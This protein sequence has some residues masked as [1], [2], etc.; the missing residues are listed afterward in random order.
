MK[1]VLA[2]II[3]I[4]ILQLEGLLALPVHPVDS[5]GVKWVSG[6]KFIEYK[7]EEHE[8]WYGIARQ[9]GISYNELRAANK[10]SG[11]QLSIGQVILVPVAKVNFSG[12][13][14]PADKT[15]EPAIK[16]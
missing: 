5:V 8:G 1:K 2:L 16:N 3:V 10:D 6:K 12:S 15:E 4:L 9:Y 13:K 14:T 7:V 11:D